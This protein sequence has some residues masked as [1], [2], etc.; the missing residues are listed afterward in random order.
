MFEL[1]ANFLAYHKHGS[2]YIWKEYLYIA[3]VLWA[4]M[5]YFFFY[6]LSMKYYKRKD[7]VYSTY[8]AEKA[9]L[10]WKVE[11]RLMQIKV[12]KTSTYIFGAATPLYL[13]AYLDESDV[14]KTNLQMPII[15]STICITSLV[16]WMRLT[17]RNKQ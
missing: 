13:L 17:R 5:V 16:I 12:F 7:Y 15:F 10:M 2:G 6:D 11:K 3:V 14:L 4:V 8:P 1:W 9:E